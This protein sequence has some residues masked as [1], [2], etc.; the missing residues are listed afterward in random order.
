MQWVRIPFEM[1]VVTLYQGM[2]TICCEATS[3]VL[4]HISATKLSISLLKKKK[5]KLRGMP[6]PMT[7]FLVARFLHVLSNA[8]ASQDVRLPITGPILQRMLRALSVMSF[9]LYKTTL[10]SNYVS[11]LSPHRGADFQVTGLFS[12]SV[13]RSGD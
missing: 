2:Y 4:I 8:N 13:Y 1:H 3:Q 12:H 5:K 7:S 6:D 10:L 9:S 11:C